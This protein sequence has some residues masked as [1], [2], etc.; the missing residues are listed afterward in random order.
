MAR[1]LIR[2][3]NRVR[4]VLEHIYTYGFFSRE[5]FERRGV[6][7][8][9]GYDKEL[10]RLLSILPP[11]VLLSKQEGKRRYFYI[12]RDYFTNRAPWLAA[13]YFLHSVKPERISLALL[14]LTRLP[15]AQSRLRVAAEQMPGSPDASVLPAL[16]RQLL[17][18]EELGY[19]EKRGR[20]Y[21][22]PPDL[23]SGLNREQLSNLYHLVSLFAYGGF[24]RTPG[25]FLR[26]TVQREFFIR[27]WTP[28]ADIFL[29]RDNCCRSVFDEQ[30]ACRLAGACGERRLVSLTKGRRTF[31]AA[32]L[33]VQ[34]D[35]RMGRWYLVCVD[36]DAQRVLR[37]RLRLI[38]QCGVLKE[39]FQ[40]GAYE[41]MAR[42]RLSDT[43]LSTADHP[44]VQVEARLLMPEGS[45]R[46][47][48]FRREIFIG[49]IVRR[50]T[51]LFYRAAVRDPLELKP[52]LRSYYP[53]L[54]I[55][56][57]RHTLDREIREELERM[58]ERYGALS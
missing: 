7:K 35:P 55:S 37:L 47:E 4:P 8:K 38:T 29:F 46:F 43:Y 49:E 23:L 42:D 3:Y 56:P 25:E 13:S 2:D 44:P 27:G 54:R 57:G 5:D 51:E 53:Y 1:E 19:I 22:L 20:R 39:T 24:P 16:R 40:A 33:Y 11:H 26:R 50:G 41:E 12:R 15:A 31:R 32:P 48:Q 18:L 30:L 14:I 10:Q 36:T 58:R 9:S 45:F 52:L 34:L 28:P 17:R 21:Q 6:I